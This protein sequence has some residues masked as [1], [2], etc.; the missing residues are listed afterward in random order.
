MTELPEQPELPLGQPGPAPSAPRGRARLEAD[1]AF[2]LRC[3]AR[4]RWVPVRGGRRLRC[5]GCRDVFPCRHACEHADCNET[6]EELTH[7]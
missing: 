2:C 1:D 7:A 6:R 5:S 3:D 4:T